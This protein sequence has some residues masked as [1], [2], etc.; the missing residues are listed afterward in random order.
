MD[1]VSFNVLQRFKDRDFFSLKKG[2]LFS[3][4]NPVETKTW[5]FHG[6]NVPT[7]WELVSTI[8]GHVDIPELVDALQE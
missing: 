6:V 3:V 8:S 1:V 5:Q 2:D 7:P 4:T